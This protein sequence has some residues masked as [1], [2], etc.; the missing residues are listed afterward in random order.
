M[1]T[2]LE[3]PLPF[4]KS[5]FKLLFPPLMSVNRLGMR[6]KAEGVTL[7]RNISTG[8][9]FGNL[10]LG[11]QKAPVR[12]VPGGAS[13]ISDCTMPGQCSRCCFCPEVA[14]VSSVALQ[15]HLRILS[16]RFTHSQRRGDFPNVNKFES[17]PGSFQ[18]RVLE[19]N[20]LKI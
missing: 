5:S 20:F 19:Q 9:A 16:L 6:V 10:P 8:C 14:R 11:D 15:F 4:P 1:E 12:P 2:L 3:Q 17:L 18:Q 7:Q 13:T